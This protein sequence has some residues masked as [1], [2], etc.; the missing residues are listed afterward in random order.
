MSEDCIF[1]KIANKQVLSDIV[2][3]DEHVV[4]IKDINPQ[5]PVHLLIVPKIHIPSMDELRPEHSALL[6]HIHLVAKS[7]AEKEGLEDGWRLVI[8]C[9]PNAKQTVFHLHVHVMGGRPMMGQMA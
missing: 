1:C 8:N 3:E 4:A 5:T 7:L 2:H 9:G 6:G